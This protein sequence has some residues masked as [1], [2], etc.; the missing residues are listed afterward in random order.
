[1]GPISGNFRG[2]LMDFMITISLV[3]T[4]TALGVPQKNFVSSVEKIKHSDCLLVQRAMPKE[5]K[6]VCVK[7][8]K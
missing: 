7:T 6:V 1:M 2:G 3:T 4:F 5:H 8:A